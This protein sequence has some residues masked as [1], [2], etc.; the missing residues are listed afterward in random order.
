MEFGEKSDERTGSRL[1]RQCVLSTTYVLI[2]YSARSTA[3]CMPPMPMRHP[4][5]SA[6]SHDDHGQSYRV[7]TRI[8]IIAI[9]RVTSLV[10]PITS[11][12]IPPNALVANASMTTV[13][14]MAIKQTMNPVT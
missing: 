11:P 1:C 10:A 8:A 2:H 7:L 12:V 5:C 6:N 4:F 14:P 13:V 9:S 3:A